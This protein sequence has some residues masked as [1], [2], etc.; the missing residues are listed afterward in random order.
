MAAVMPDSWRCKVGQF[1]DPGCR[2][3]EFV[4]CRLGNGQ[5]WR[6]LLGRWFRFTSVLEFLDL[7]DAFSREHR[8]G[9]IGRPGATP[10]C[11]ATTGDSGILGRLRLGN[12][13]RRSVVTHH[14]NAQ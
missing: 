12:E 11:P 14:V 2:R 7:L 6:P 4:T 3:P 1:P 10:A 13:L 5:L 9:S 8:T